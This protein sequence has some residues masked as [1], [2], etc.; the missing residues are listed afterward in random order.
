MK[1]I[2]LV[3]KINTRLENKKTSNIKLINSAIKS[4]SKRGI[5]ET[6][7]SNVSQGAGL[8]QGIVNFHF[9]SKELL[10]IETLRYISNEYL[11][12][13]QHRL[14][15]A[16]NDPRKKI[17][18]IIKN[19]F[20]K[21]ICNRDKIAVWY[22][23]LS[24]VKFKP[25]YLQICKERDEYYSEIVRSIF[26]ELINKD[27]NK[28][29]SAKKITTSLLALTMGLWLDQ[30]VDSDIFNRNEAKEICLNFVKNIFPK[31]FKGF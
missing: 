1:N 19:D 20:D 4:I 21:K 3:K 15:S 28:K 22:T 6:T 9:K 5:N 25:V 16:G 24:E 31:Q 11:A 13:F 12:A 10:F 30:L 2:Q 29:L 23:F 27:K 7:M 26:V 8:S 18:A 14:K 17:I